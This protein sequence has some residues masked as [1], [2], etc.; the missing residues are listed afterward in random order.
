MSKA[1]EAIPEKYR[2]AIPYLCVKGAAEALEFYKRAFGA[3]ELE[4]VNM[5]GGIV[6]HAEITIGG[7]SGAVV[8]LADEFPDMGF[9]GPRSIGGSPVVIH[10]Y[11][12]DVDGFTK[13]AIEAGAKVLEPVADKFYGDRSCK[14]EDP[15]GHIWNFA[16]HV[17]DV[18]E[19]ELKRRA[20]AA[21]GA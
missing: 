6:G 8:M 1:V 14:L 13:R 10:L 15:F 9:R 7:G 3:E 17:E 2:G 5:P 20:A 4:R 18:P 21:F 11:V 19:E 16:T 12:N